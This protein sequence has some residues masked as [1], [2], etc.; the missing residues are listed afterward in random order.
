MN[1][2][3]IIE[4]A[5]QRLIA[6]NE[7]VYVWQSHKKAFY[8]EQDIF[9]CFDLIALDRETGATAF[10]QVTSIQHLSDRI[11]KCVQIFSSLNAMFP[12]NSHVWAYDEKNDTWKTH[13][14]R[15]I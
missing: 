6:E 13:Q 3:S 15:E 1:E 7:N 4:K 9:G 10:I 12:T 8:P 2:R 14:L 11:K 5:K